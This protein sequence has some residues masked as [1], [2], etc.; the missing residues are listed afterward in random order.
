MNVN[1]EV[2]KHFKREAKRFFTK[3][4]SLKNELLELKEKLMLNPTFGTSLGSNAFKIRLAVQS[5][6]KGKSGGLRI[7][8]FLDTEIIGIVE[9]ETNR[10]TKV[11]L[12][13]IYDKS[14]VE[15]ITQKR[16]K[17]VNRKY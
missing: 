9:Q 14:E 8:T 15:T 16:N 17:R 12:F 13:S 3:F 10:V 6:G 4:A 11:Y 1:V 7:I 2:T 5:K